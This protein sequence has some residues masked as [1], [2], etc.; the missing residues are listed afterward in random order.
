[1]LLKRYYA[2]W[3]LCL[4]FLTVGLAPARDVSFIVLADNRNNTVQYRAAL[5]E[6]NDMTVNPEPAIPSPHFLVAC[7]DIDPVAS[8]MAIYTDTLMYPNLPPYYPVVGNHEFETPSDMD[9]ILNSMIPNLKNVVNGGK[10]GTYSFD[11]GNVHCIVL[12][13]YSTNGEGEV[14]T[15]LQAWLQQDLNA[16][17]QDH[18][19]VFGHEPAFPRHR[20]MGDSLDQFPESRNAFW[21]MLVIEPRVRAYFC[22][23]THYYSRMRVVDPTK[24][25]A[26]G[27]PDQNGGVYQVDCGAAGHALSDGRLTLVYVHVDEDAVRF[28]VVT[29]PRNN[30]QWT[31][32]DQWSIRGLR[33]FGMQLIEPLAGDEISG[34]TNVTWSVSGEP[35]PPLITTLYVSSDAG[36]HWDRLWTEGAEDTTYAWNTANNPDGTRYMLRVVS[37]GD[38]GFGMV[39]SEGTF[40]INNPGNGPPEIALK[41]PT[42]GDTLRGEVNVEWE[43]ADADGDP[44]LISLETSIDDGATWP[45]LAADETNDGLYTW[46]TQAMPN[47]TRYMLKLR[48]TDG[49]VWVEEIS[50]TFAIQN[51]REVSSDLV[52]HHLSGPGSGT[53]IAHIIDRSALTDHW[54]R[55]TFDDTTSEMT[56]YDVWDIDA[57]TLVVDDATEMDGQTEGPLFDGIRLL[58]YNY[59]APV[60]DFNQTGWTVGTSDLTYHI[61]LP[62]IDVGTEI[63]TGIAYPADYEITAYD[64]QVDTSSSFLGAAEVPMYFTVQNMTEGYQVDVIYNEIDGDHTISRFDEIYI[65]EEDEA[66]QPML[67]WLIFFSGRETSIPPVAGD[68]FTLKTLKPFTSEDVFEFTTGLS[69]DRGDVTGDGSINVLDVVA[70]VRHILGIETLV[71]NALW[72]ADCNGDGEIDLQDLVGIVSVILGTGECG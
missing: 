35:D 17:A 14:D 39:Q 28:R 38:S 49:T 37:K 51:D 7:G 68:V 64:H 12:D 72:R 23:H 41:A 15:N 44:L 43:A 46:D 11:Y 69:G 59:A 47:S 22:G 21:D 50:G 66:G 67:T 70:V 60:V 63:I 1:M 8:N 9:Y 25:G 57:G 3:A 19:F 31:V 56:T 33:R 36:A 58:I 54:Y 52:F 42:G 71:G 13:E 62:E 55:L 53:I 10:Q 65:L 34:V 27:Y 5:Q 4:V 29:S 40:T 6:I 24:V 18:V 2:W 32:T 20:H 61:S 48:C 30:V 16:T 45:S 26:A